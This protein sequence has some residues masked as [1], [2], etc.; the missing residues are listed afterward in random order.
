MSDFAET[1]RPLTGLGMASLVLGTVALMLFFL[2]V[3][4]IPISVLG[5]VFGLVG[6]GAALF[7]PGVSLRWG[8]G[9]ICMS[10]LA[11]LLN[12]GIVF[13]PAGYVPTGG[14]QPQPWRGVPDRPYV[15]PPASP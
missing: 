4:G 10:A 12:V 14:H 8:L 2:P 13:A 15:P 9:G 7:R 3:L 11:L 5:L 6:F 1:Y